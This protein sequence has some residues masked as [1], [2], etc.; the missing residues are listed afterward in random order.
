[1]LRQTGGLGQGPG[2]LRDEESLFL[3]AIMQEG[4]LASHGMTALWHIYPTWQIAK[5]FLP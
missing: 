4:F 3:P 1:M 2:K 5:N